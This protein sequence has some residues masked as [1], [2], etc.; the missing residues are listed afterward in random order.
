MLTPR[1][2]GADEFL[3]DL[4]VFDRKGGGD[5]YHGGG[6]ARFRLSGYHRQM[7]TM[8]FSLVLITRTASGGPVKDVER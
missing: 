2:R 3:R 1:P 6:F 4:V 5:G 7:R 8:L